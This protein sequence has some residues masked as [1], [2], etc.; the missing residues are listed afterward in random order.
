MRFILLL[1]PLLLL[2]DIVWQPEQVALYHHNSEL[3]RRWAWSVIGPYNF[4]GDERILDLGCGDGKI[5]NDLKLLVPD[6]EVVGIDP[7]RHMIEWAQIMYPE[8]S[9]SQQTI[10]DVEGIFDIIVSFYTLHCIDDAGATLREI[11]ERLNPG[12]KLLATIPG[13][14]NPAFSQAVEATVTDEKWAAHFEGFEWGGSFYACEVWKDLLEVADLKPVR[15][16][17]KLFADPFVNADEFALWM[18]G[19]LP[20]VQPIPAE[21][22]HQF[23]LDVIERYVAIAPERV[24]DKGQIDSRFGCIQMIATKPHGWFELGAPGRR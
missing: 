5:T 4:I 8:T 12:G 15:V 7:S 1:T 24:G 21:E 11:S 16:E 2:A 3:Q 13:L 23:C 17:L 20:M 10:E 19:T 6:G 18:E 9:F 22:R 14:G